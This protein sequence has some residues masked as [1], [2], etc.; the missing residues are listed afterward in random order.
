MFFYQNLGQDEIS[1]SGTSFLN[2]YYTIVYY[3]HLLI[4][5]PR[6]EASNVEKILTKF[7]KSG[8][9]PNQIGPVTLY[10]GQRSYIVNYMR[11]NR[12]LKKEL[13][14]ELILQFADRFL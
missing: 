10:E 12:S 8:V 3:S 13:Y 9:V 1:S 2:R 7:F 11:F 4:I 14:K 6:M 5:G